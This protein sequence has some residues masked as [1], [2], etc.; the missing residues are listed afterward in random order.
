MKAHAPPPWH[1]VLDVD[2]TDT[3]LHGEQEERFLHAYYDGDCY[4][5]L[6]V[7]CGRHLLV[8]YLRPSGID[9]A[10]HAWAILS[11]LVKVLRAHWPRVEIVVRGDSGFCRWRMLRWCEAHGVCYIVGVAKDSRL[12][13]KSDALLERA[14]QGLAIGHT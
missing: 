13:R 12:H 11:L 9:P 4:L 7:F 2:A 6:Y 1:L 8:N 3:P 5:P 14:A 10:R